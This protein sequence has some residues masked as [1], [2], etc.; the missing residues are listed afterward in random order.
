M[1]GFF[2]RVWD[3][4]K[5]LAGLMLPVAGK[6][7]GAGFSRGVRWFLHVVVL[8]AILVGLYFL[9][10]RL[11]SLLGRR[12]EAKLGI[13][14]HIWLPLL[15][16]LFYVLCW[17][18]WW[19]WTLLVTEDEYVQFPDITEAW[20]EA[21]R[22]LDRAGIDLREVPLF[23]V[24]GRT[25]G[26]PET[27]FQAARLPLVVKQAPARPE[28]PLHVYA[29]REAVYVTCEKVSLLGSHA[30]LLAGEGS[31]VPGS[32]S[33]EDPGTLAMIE[34]TM[35][36][37]N[38]PS[39]VPAIQ[40]ILERA[41]KEN[42]QLTPEEK[43]RIRTMARKDRSLKPPVRN[44]EEVDRHAAR[45][46]HLCRLLV[47][48]RHPYCPINGT[49]VH[50][51]FAATDT[52]QDALDAGASC[53]RDL[54]VARRVLQ[55][56]SPTIALVS[57][58]ETA[59][60]FRSFLEAFPEKQ[61]LQRVG[62]RC[63]LV[64]HLEPRSKTGENLR[65]QMLESLAEW[66]CGAVMP[67]WVYKHFRLEAPGQAGVEAVL[68]GNAQ[69]FL[70]MHHL[71]ER[72]HRLGRL[73]AQAFAAEDDDPYLFGGCYLAGTGAESARDQAFVAGVFQRLASEENHVSWTEQALV[74]E[75]NYRRWTAIGQTALGVLAVA[76]LALLGFMLFG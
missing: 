4:L 6:V 23:L 65:A 17:L 8:A 13:L 7:R 43:R 21:R 73:L 54:A 28:A 66:V 49:L 1:G 5:W 61:R 70:F 18:G 26:P 52:D 9:N 76:T 74:D 75:A 44:P 24:V 67:G 12:V 41:R 30:A 42:R 68:R 48:D 25:E 34:M 14:R 64:P 22:A 55:V 62:Q 27:L 58:L 60:G 38:A 35:R 37:G 69:M 20:E 53:Q 32:L 15:F 57:D 39:A 3:A 72:Q 51:P 56:E 46:E 45:L 71:R 63:P 50:V 29:S 33:D 19:L 2:T 10:D 40:A 11:L 59:P 47:R 36:P 31:E 16:M